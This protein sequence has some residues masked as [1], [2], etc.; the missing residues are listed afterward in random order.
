MIDQSITKWYSGVSF[1]V[2]IAFCLVFSL[3]C[4]AAE[5]A[6]VGIDTTKPQKLTLAVSKSIVVRSPGLVKRVSLSAPDIAD[7]L[8]LSP[9]QIYLT[10]KVPGITSITFWNE[11]DEISAVLDLEVLPDIDRLKEKLHEM[12]PQ[13]ENIMVSAI[14]SKIA[15]SGTITSTANLSQVLELT[16]AYA[17][18]KDGEYQIINFLSVGG[19][20]QVMLEVRVS[21]MSRRIAK[22]LGINFN[23]IGKHGDK[24]GVSRIGGLTTGQTIP[25][26]TQLPFDV[27]SIATSLTDPINLLFNFTRNGASMMFFIDALKEKGLIKVLAEP[28][29]ITYSGKTANFLVGGE[30]PVPVPQSGGAGTGQTTITIEWKRFGVGLNFTPTVLNNEKINMLIEP[31]VSKLDFNS[32]VVIQGSTIPAL[33]VTRVST[34]VE[35]GDGQSF[36][37]AGLLQDDIAQTVDEHPFLGQVPILGGL[38][39]SNQFLKNETELIIVVTPHL[40]KPV[41]MTKQTLPTDQYVEPNDLEFYFLGKLEGFSSPIIRGSRGSASLVKDKEGGL[42]GN[43][44]HVKP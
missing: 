31:E 17:S 35:L 34:T 27:G 4:W 2:I 10:G 6:V 18:E 11:V 14:S 9:R 26:N 40:V 32:G 16:Q 38:F 23:Y 12:F 15:L 33:D 24:F 44:G 39:R 22:R 13:E 42:E 3:R 36:A 30:F 21:E 19:A 5:P 25:P 8:V 41:D 20:H 29:L 1:L 7:I 43:F 28:T 37:I